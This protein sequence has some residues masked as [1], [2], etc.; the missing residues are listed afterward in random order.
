MS[1]TEQR[2]AVASKTMGKA[3]AKVAAADQEMAN[4]LSKVLAD[5]MQ[6]IREGR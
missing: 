1:N 2:I 6:R 4:R 5:E 3:L